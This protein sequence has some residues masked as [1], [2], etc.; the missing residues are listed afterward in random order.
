[1]KIPFLTKIE[2]KAKDFL[3][4]FVVLFTGIIITFILAF[5]AKN[6]LDEDNKLQLEIA[7]VDLKFRIQ[8]MLNS[9]VQ[10]S[11]SSA[12]F[13]MSSDTVT[14]GDWKHFVEKSQISKHLKGFQGIAYVMIVSNKQLENHNQH[15]KEVLS[16]DY[17]VFPSGI[18]EMYTPIVYIEPLQDRN[19]KALGFNISTNP[20]MKM[21]IEKAMDSNKTILTDKVTL[22]QESTPET[23]SGFVMYTPIYDKNL[24][25]NTINERRIAIKGW[26][27]SSFRMVNFM[28]GVFDQPN[29]NDHNQL[30]LKIYD[31]DHISSESLLFD[32]KNILNKYNDELRSN[33]LML[34]IELN[35]KKWTLQF[36]QQI[37]PPSFSSIPYIVVTGGIVISIL[38]SLLVFTL[39]NRA[40]YAKRVAEKLTINLSDKNNE[41]VV[42]NEL[43]KE[44]HS[45][46]IISKEKAEESEEKLKLIANNLVNGMIYQV[47]MR[48][49]KRRKFTYLSESVQQLYGCTATEAIENPDLIYGK[50]H[51]DDSD[52]LNKKEKEALKTMSIFKSEVRV[53]NPDGTIRWSYFVSR[54]RII[55]GLVCWDG[56]EVDITEQ[57]NVENELLIAKEKAEISS[58]LKSAFLANMSHEIRTPMNAILGFSDLL[59]QQELTDEK[60]EKYFEI[61]KKSGGR[62]LTVIND[63][64]DISKVES[65]QMEILI[66]EFNILEQIKEVHALFNTEATEKGI[67]LNIKNSLPSNETNIKSDNHKINAILVNLVKNAIKYCDEGTIEIG[68]EKQESILKF[69]IKDTGI[70][71]D[72]NRQIAIFDRFVQADI[73]DV[74]ALQGSGLG[75]SISKAYVEMLGGEIWVDSEPG[76]GATFYFTIP[77]EIKISGDISSGQNVISKLKNSINKLKVLVVEDDESSE[78]YISQIVDDLSKEI[79]FASNGAEAVE[80]CRNN[81]DIDL[82]LMDVKMPL[83]NGYEATKIIRQFNKDVI[84]IAQTAFALIGDKQKAITAGCN[85]YITKPINKEELIEMIKKQLS[86]LTVN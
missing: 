42:I 79:L 46:I 8:S 71:I 57:K 60:Q 48:D 15:F 33:T 11:R 7:A 19:I 64:I 2:P 20:L 50:I 6:N 25:I 62:L 28:K 5:Y 12:S 83:M 23:S 69:H 72:K 61:I 40:A 10:F 39:L 49:E 45:E 30:H 51:K 52:D 70:G 68:V 54:P 67:L 29:S 80:L 17:S 3:T 78:I 56:I 44:S 31:G 41:L 34:P 75:L 63:I 43:L 58:R 82:V 86:N 21:A 24:P 77:G 81:S 84:I 36:T 26:A 55:S 37:I 74:K 18:S 1:M 35:G 16:N 13:F 27:A 14:K 4:A 53:F 73:E 85:D 22:I 76:K 47:V 38:L 32:N 66:S 59:K 65:G 9:H